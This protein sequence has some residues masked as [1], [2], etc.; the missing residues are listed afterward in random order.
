MN[1]YPEVECRVAQSESEKP[2]TVSG[3][4]ENRRPITPRCERYMRTRWAAA[5]SSSVGQL[6]AR[7]SIPTVY[8]TSG[9]V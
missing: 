1:T 2:D 9:L 3:S 4:C 7:Q 5:K 8:A 6:I